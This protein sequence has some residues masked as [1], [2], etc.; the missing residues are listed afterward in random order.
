M[1][2]TF[3]KFGL[4]ASAIWSI[5]FDQF[6]RLRHVLGLGPTCIEISGLGPFGWAQCKPNYQFLG[7]PIYWL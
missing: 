5:F 3:Y 4:L 7:R 1:H 6:G 2:H